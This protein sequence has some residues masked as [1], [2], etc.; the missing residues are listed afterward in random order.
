[1][2]RELNSS[3][4][5]FLPPRMI[6]F[7][8]NPSDYSSSDSALSSPRVM[9]YRDGSS[10]EE[11]LYFKTLESDDYVSVVNEGNYTIKYNPDD[12]TLSEINKTFYIDQAS[13]LKFFTALL[14]STLV[15]I[16]SSFPYAT[17]YERITY[18]EWVFFC[19]I[20][21]AIFA[22]VFSSQWIGSIFD[23]MYRHKYS[24]ST[25]PS[26]I[27]RHLT[28]T[29][30][31]TLYSL[32]YSIKWIELN[33]VLLWQVSI[34]LFTISWFNVFYNVINCRL[35]SSITIS[36]TSA[37]IRI[38]R[39]LLSCIKIAEN[40]ARDSRSSC[41]SI[42]LHFDKR[43]NIEILIAKQVNSMFYIT[44]GQLDKLDMYEENVYDTCREVRNSFVNMFVG[45]SLIPLTLSVLE[46]Y[47]YSL[48][49][50]CSDIKCANAFEWLSFILCSLLSMLYMV[51]TYDIHHN[52]MKKLALV[53]RSKQDMIAA[54]K[55]LVVQAVPLSCACIIGTTRFNASYAI[56][57]KIAAKFGMP[58]SIGLTF[59]YS[60]LSIVFIID[61]AACYKIICRSYK[62]LLSILCM[63]LV[64][65]SNIFPDIIKTY[66]RYYSLRYYYKRLKWFLR[67]CE[68]TTLYILYDKLL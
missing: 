47:G 5:A 51:A 11:G 15:G 29:L 55:S 32:L 20:R 12:Q 1:M 44:N 34:A 13:F 35:G 56:F 30:F 58:Y 41:D 64:P 18:V 68:E 10:S 36:T 62:K 45:F 40:I 49:K 54:V 46:D 38:R 43:C 66:I 61:T 8:N 39:V 33:D 2:I 25:L 6:L 23:Y 52:N 9:L 24:S 42:F 31:A 16:L 19:L 60:M 14:I 26:G 50:L 48:Y 67:N 7:N 3:G 63:P 37:K 27:A 57:G 22:F 65:Y 17:Y 4:D 53:F 21:T 59:I 28:C